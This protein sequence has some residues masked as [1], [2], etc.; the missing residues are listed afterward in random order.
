MKKRKLYI[1]GAGRWGSVAYSC[2]QEDSKILGYIDSNPEKWGTQVNQVK[3]YPPDIL[4][5]K[6]AMVV[7]A[8][9][10]NEGIERLLQEVYGLESIVY[11]E[12][13][14]KVAQVSS[15]IHNKK[16]ALNDNSII[17]CFGGGLGNQMFQYALMKNYLLREE[18]VYADLDCY[19]LP[20]NGV[21]ELTEVF[22]NIKLKVCDNE[23]KKDLTKRH[24]DG[25]ISGKFII[26]NEDKFELDRSLLNISSGIIRGLHQNYYFAGLI[27][28]AIL[29]DFEFNIYADE[30]LKDYC[31]VL[32]NSSN[33]IG[34]HIRRGDYLSSKYYPILG[35][36]CT[37]E[38]YTQA[39][40]YMEERVDNCRFCF[41]S[42]D[43]QWVKEKFP[44]Y[45]AIYMEANM[46]HEYENW[47]DMCLMSYCSHNIIANSTFSWWGAWLNKR[48]DKIVIA[49]RKWSKVYEFPDICPPEWVRL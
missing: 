35:D 47:Y 42:D 13:C 5:E 14:E 22:K 45:N 16:E 41:F 20:K 36:V 33:I 17:I 7:I 48:K 49:P 29:H 39:M 12:C 19:L 10:Q 18:Y 46:F 21:F 6:K 44:K 25:N 37:Q 32:G 24:V 1:W 4:K 31:S 27:R 9:K 2:Y 30:K 11:F 40:D 34:V 3:I 15:G 43:I 23:Q 28:D 8:V 38:Y 26:S